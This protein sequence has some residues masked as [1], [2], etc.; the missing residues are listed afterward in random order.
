MKYVAATSVYLH[1]L[2]LKYR[3]ERK[4]VYASIQRDINDSIRVKRK[5]PMDVYFFE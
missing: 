1:T 2:I 5:R 4:S 3:E